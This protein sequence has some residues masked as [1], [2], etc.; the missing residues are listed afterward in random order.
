MGET[1]N[2]LDKLLIHGNQDFEVEQASGLRRPTKDSS[3]PL[4]DEMPDDDSDAS[5][6]DFGSDVDVRESLLTDGGELSPQETSS[7]CFEAS[8]SS[9][10][11]SPGVASPIDSDNGV[12][13]R[14]DDASES[15]KEGSNGNSEDPHPL[16]MKTQ[17]LRPRKNRV[18]ANG[19]WAEG[20]PSGK[21]E[22]VKEGKTSVVKKAVAPASLPRNPASFEE[23]HAAT[24]PPAR[25]KFAGGLWNGNEE[26]ATRP[27]GGDCIVRQSSEILYGM[28]S[29]EV[30]KQRDP[31]GLLR[32][33]SELPPPSPSENVGPF[34]ARHS[35]YTV[36]NPVGVASSRKPGKVFGSNS[37]WWS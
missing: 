23:L 27:S 17:V 19:L 26:D 18:F 25:R 12:P 24:R 8:L 3:C 37:A 33:L 30:S 28:G 10:E 2:L 7:Y 35:R 16:S 1:T 31:P 4:D 32:Q 20:A 36:K 13:P 34:E 11:V 21:E 6:R 5:T 14:C 9:G 22:Q 29:R 15:N